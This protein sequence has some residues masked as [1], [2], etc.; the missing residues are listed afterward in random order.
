MCDEHTNLATT[1]FEIVFSPRHPSPHKLTSSET[2][3]QPFGFSFLATNFFVEVPKGGPFISGSL[4]G[5]R[6]L[7]HFLRHIPSQAPGKNQVPKWVNLSHPR[8]LWS[9]GLGVVQHACCWDTFC[10]QHLSSP[11]KT[12]CLRPESPECVGHPRAGVQHLRRNPKAQES[13]VLKTR[14]LM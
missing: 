7:A 4:R 10:H 14:G 3:F 11:K 1:P 2:T 12:N 8:N 13:H 6:G 9:G 5:N